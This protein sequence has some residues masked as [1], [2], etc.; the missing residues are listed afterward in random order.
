MNNI[1]LGFNIHLDKD[2]RINVIENLNEYYSRDIDKLKRSIME[3]K[4]IIK[5][6]LE[7]FKQ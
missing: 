5:E 6:L 7:P 3:R 4:L 1:I 2:Q